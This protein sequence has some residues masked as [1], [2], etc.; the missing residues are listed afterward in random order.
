MAGNIFLNGT[1]GDMTYAVNPVAMAKGLARLNSSL[2]VAGLI[3]NYSQEASNQGTRASAAVRIPIRGALSAVPKVPGTAATYQQAATTK[4]DITLN[5]HKT[6]DFLVEDFG[7]L[8]D[9]STIEGYMV[10]AGATLAEAI[11]NS[12]IGLYASAGQILGSS[13]GGAS[14]ALLATVNKA[15][16][17]AKWREVNPKYFIAGPEAVNDLIQIATLSQYTVN[18]QDQSTIRD[19]RI[20]RLYGFDV[21]K[22]NLIPAV[23]GSPT[24]EHCMA[25]QP[26]A[27]GIAFVDMST[28]G[29]PAGYGAGSEVQAMNWTDDNGNMAYSMRSIVGY[30]Q[31]E[32][33]MKVSVDTIYGVGVVNSALLFDVLV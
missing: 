6:V 28:N 16:M 13:T 20:G 15:A 21:I 23:A 9:P 10:D 31:E 30:S 26:E 11:E 12:V 4:S 29:L 2:V 33:G 32:R 19:A 17:E 27:M 25:F 24:G 8:F 14:L 7:G 5:L 22:S 3:T 1:T 18:G